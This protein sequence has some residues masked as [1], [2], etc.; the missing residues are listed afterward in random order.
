MTTHKVVGYQSIPT[1]GSR[2]LRILF[3]DLYIAKNQACF[4]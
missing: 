1:T 3:K 2:N 4:S